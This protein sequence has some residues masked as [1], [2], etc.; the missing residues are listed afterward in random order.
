MA[1]ERL[2]EHETLILVIGS[3]LHPARQA[4]SSVMSFLLIHVLDCLAFSLFL[5]LFNAFHGH[6]RRRGLSYPPGPPSLPIIG[7]LLDVPNEAP[8][9]AYAEMSKKHGMGITLLIAR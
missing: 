8:W 4:T 1:R 6:R 5:Y 7:N 3:Y 2:T 9:I